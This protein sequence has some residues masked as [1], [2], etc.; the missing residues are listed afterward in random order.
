M[1]TNYKISSII[2]EFAKEKSWALILY[3]ILMIAAPIEL[4]VQPH[5]YGK[6]I[7]GV[8]HSKPGKV[9]E[10]NKD[11]IYILIGLWLI[12]QILY[13]S[14]D[15]LDSYIIPDIQEFT[16]N[17]L[18]N[19]IFEAFKNDYKELEIA[20]IISKLVKLPIIIKGMFHQCRNYFIP[21]IFILVVA[22]SYFFYI[23][24]TLGIIG[25]I[26][27][28]IFIFL[29]Y[30]YS[31]KCVTLSTKRDKLN[32]KLHEE[33]GD[34]LNNLLPIY[35]SNSLKKELKIIED[36]ET[37]Y[38]D[39]YRDS[40]FCSLKLKLRYALTYFIFF[41]SINGYSFYLFKQGK[42]SLK[43][44]TS[45]LIVVL[46]LISN[47]SSTAGEIK[48]LINNIGVINETQ[49]YLDALFEN[50]NKS[51]HIPK[52]KIIIPQG[53]IVFKDVYFKYPTA[54]NYLFS[55]LNLHI[56]PNQSLG[57]IGQIGSGKTT[58]I[59]LLMKFNI[60][61]RGQI[62]IDNQEIKSFSS[63]DIRTHISYV[64]QTPKLFNRSVIENIIYGADHPIEAKKKAMDLI[65]T[66]ELESMIKALPKGLDTVAGKNG[67]KLSGGQRQTVFLL[68]SLLRD[69]KII[70]LDEPTSAL[71]N[72]SREKIFNIIRKLME[73]KTL[74]A[75]THDLE[76][77]KIVDRT[78]EFKGGEI[79][80]DT[81]K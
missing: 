80:S 49:N 63:E 22:V 50:D 35:S 6:I 26:G 19:N 29:I 75:I 62:L 58:I 16:R 56:K 81:L 27:I 14:M 39:V 51:K 10:T 48:E 8:S 66:L 41:L 18:V 30:S 79:I 73:N 5:F 38:N 61:N 9:I 37:K 43:Y 70:I 60:H 57:I 76:L 52:S 59:K 31:G 28:T 3:S 68:R 42:I 33:I 40:I 46:Y 24:V 15:I 44:L 69:N 53:E 71:D 20:D 64:P 32:N 1:Q 74:I 2:K 55:K 25:T 45:I 23:N 13:G 78:I 67:E 12:I 17:K 34:I 4:V 65:K 7:D 11:I 47:L 54:D 36:E 72:Q 21:T 77:L